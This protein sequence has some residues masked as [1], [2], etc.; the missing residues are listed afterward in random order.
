MDLNANLGT[1][2]SPM[3]VARPSTAR[4][5]RDGTTSIGRLAPARSHH[6]P[7]SNDDRLD[8]KPTQVVIL[9]MRLV[10]ED[11]CLLHEIFSLLMVL[12]LL[13]ATKSLVRLATKLLPVGSTKSTAPR[14][15]STV[16]ECDEGDDEPNGKKDGEEA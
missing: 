2:V 12:S 15:H 11:A 10:F 14:R 1:I 5:A 7:L 16:N 4:S 3:V 9:M 6:D 8:R 13:V